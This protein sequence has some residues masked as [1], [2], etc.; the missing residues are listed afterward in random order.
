MRNLLLVGLLLIGSNVCFGDLKFRMQTTGDRGRDRVVYVRGERIRTEDS[1]TGRV[2]IRE[3]DLHRTIQLDPG[4]KTYRVFPILPRPATSPAT[5]VSASGTE[6][7]RTTRRELEETGEVKQMFG[8]QAQHLRVFVY[9]EPGSCSDRPLREALLQERDGW[10]IEIPPVPECPAPTP[11]DRV[12]MRA[13]DQPDQFVRTDGSMTPELLPAKVDVKGTRRGDLETEFTAQ[14]SDLSTE[15]LDA[16]LFDIPP[17]YHPVA[18]QDCSKGPEIA[19]KLDDGSTVYRAGCGISIPR[20]TYHLEPEYSEHARKK[21]ISGVVVL[22]L[23]IDKSG[24]VR[25]VKVERSLEPSLDQNAIA[26]VSQWKFEPGKK[27]GEPVAIQTKAEV[28]FNIYSG[29][30]HR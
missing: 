11:E 23:V 14:I 1:E 20:M 7:K 8:M 12:G 30:G 10:Y 22:S 26:A 24:T 9:Q 5:T 15:P 21:K 13:F 28:S 16:G 29:P 17:D 27:D 4:L 25:D 18:E 2:S 6:C 19:E 3:C